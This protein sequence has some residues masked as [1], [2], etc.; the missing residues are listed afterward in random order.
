MSQRCDEL[1]HRAYICPQLKRTGDPSSMIPTRRTPSGSC[2]G[3]YATMIDLRFHLF[4]RSSRVPLPLLSRSVARHNRHTQSA[5]NA[6]ARAVSRGSPSSVPRAPARLLS[7]PLGYSR[8]DNPTLDRRSI[9]SRSMYSALSI[10]SGAHSD[11]QEF[12]LDSLHGALAG[13]LFRW[14]FSCS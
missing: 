10:V 14:S 6:S 1:W 2:D 4:S 13:I 3:G 12:T 7:G 11:P 5:F 8:C 9:N